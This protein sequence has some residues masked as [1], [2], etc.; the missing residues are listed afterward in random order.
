MKLTGHRTESIYRRYAIVSDAELREA[1]LKLMGK[2]TG[3][4]TSI[5][6]AGAAGRSSWP[7]IVHYV[8]DDPPDR[9]PSRELKRWAG[10]AALL[11]GAPGLGKAPRLDA[12]PDH[13]GDL[14]ALEPVEVLHGRGRQDSLQE[15][16]AG[17][18]SGRGAP[19]CLE[20]GDLVVHQGGGDAAARRQRGHADHGGVEVA[21][22]AWPT[23]AAA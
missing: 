12:R 8:E 15:V 17:D 18:E 22:V 6:T 9:P 11:D 14:G 2:G 21:E 4:G 19:R 20:A 1:T 23:S 7:G 5:G 16:V 3:Q 10:A 13:V